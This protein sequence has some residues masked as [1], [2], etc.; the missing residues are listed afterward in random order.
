MKIQLL[1]ALFT[2]MTLSSY[3]QEVVLKDGWYEIDR[4]Q[5]NILRID[6][7]T[8]ELLSIKK[9]SVIEVSHFKSYKLSTDLQGEDYVAVYFDTEGTEKWRKMTKNAI[10]FKIVFILDN[11]IFSSPLVNAEITVGVCA[12]NKNQY[13]QGKWHK[14]EKILSKLQKK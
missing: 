5:E 1:V 12:F 3:T 9:N 2:L 7:S 6:S 8:R 4:T 13:N 11:E 10:G 14:L